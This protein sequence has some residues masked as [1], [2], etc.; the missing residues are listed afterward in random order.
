L[1]RDLYALA[2]LE[3]SSLIGGWVSAGAVKGWVFFRDPHT[4]EPHALRTGPRD[5][6]PAAAK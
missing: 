4:G 2:L 1:N 3:R 6:S 5:T